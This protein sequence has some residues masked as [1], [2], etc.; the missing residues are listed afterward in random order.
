MILAIKPNTTANYLMDTAEFDDGMFWLI[1]DPETK[2]MVISIVALAA[3]MLSYMFILVRMMLAR[4]VQRRRSK[5]EQEMRTYT[6]QAAMTATRFIQ[7][8]ACS[9]HPQSFC[10]KYYVSIGA[11]GLAVGQQLTEFLLIAM[12]SF[13]LKAVDCTVQLMSLY[14]LMERGYPPVLVYGYAG[15]VTANVCIYAVGMLSPRHYSAFS[16]VLVDY[17]YVSLADIQDSLATEFT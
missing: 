14:Q 9:T 10:R 2:L 6:Q 3:I 11:V 16:Q 17:M 13:G 7:R 4:K 1:I 12:Q 5:I 15:L 8:Q